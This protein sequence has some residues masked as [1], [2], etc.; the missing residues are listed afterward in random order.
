MGFGSKLK[1]GLK[2]IGGF[3]KKILPAALPIAASF[4]P[5]VGPLVSKGLSAVG[6][7]LGFGSG[8]GEGSTAYSQ[9]NAEGVQQLPQTT[10][11][12]G[13]D[14][15][16]LVSGLAP[17]GAGALNYLG[18]RS[19]N[20]SN[21]QMAQQQMDFQE[22]M[23]NTGY[24]RAVGDMSSA[25]LNPMLAYSQGPASSPGGASAV[26]GN[27]LGA[28]VSSAFAGAQSIATLDQMAATTDQ[29]NQ[30][31]NLLKAQ[32]YNAT[33][34]ADRIAAQTKV[35]NAQHGQIEAE[36]DRIRSD[37]VSQGLHQQGMRL[38]M[39]A[40]ENLNWMANTPWGKYITPFLNDAQSVMRMA[41]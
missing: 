3:A 39:S 19:A 9:A 23:S 12:P 30:Q 40:R 17:L 1:K 22:R 27:E 36:I 29:A 37:I 6:S 34:E 11:T 35:S 7:F 25:G 21:A 26:M 18:Q 14:W 33:L 32:A 8:G 16:K 2:K 24:Q 20:A 5:G 38:G 15:G 31:S 13:F 4:I 41:R 28:G 10:V